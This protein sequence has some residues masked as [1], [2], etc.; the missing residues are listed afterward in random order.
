MNHLDVQ[1]IGVFDCQPPIE[2][3]TYTVNLPAPHNL[4]VSALCTDGTRMHSLFMG[5]VLNEL[6]D[7]DKWNEGDFIDIVD[8]DDATLRATVGPLVDKSFVEAF[9][10]K[11]P[12]V[13]LITVGPVAA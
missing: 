13:R 4:W 8:Q 6:I 9:A 2:N 1:L 12:G 3:F 5:F 7:A 11:T 10:S